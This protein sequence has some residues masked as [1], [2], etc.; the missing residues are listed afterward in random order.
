M[1]WHLTD[2]VHVY[3]THKEYAYKR[4]KIEFFKIWSDVAF[5]IN[6]LDTGILT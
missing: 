6:R 3:Y 4:S 1:F 5:I 2:K